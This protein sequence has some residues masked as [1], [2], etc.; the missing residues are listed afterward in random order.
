MPASQPKAAEQASYDGNDDDDETPSFR[1]GPAPVE[2]TSH[3]HGVL[4]ESEQAEQH[5]ECGVR[6]WLVVRRR[7]HMPCV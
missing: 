5:P 7:C 4:A 1:P 6:A 2:A 3:A